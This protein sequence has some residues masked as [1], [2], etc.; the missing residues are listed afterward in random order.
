M[1]Q[2]RALDF[3]E[4]QTRLKT[5]CVIKWEKYTAYVQ[6][7]FIFCNEI[8]FIIITVLSLVCD[9]ASVQ[10]FSIFYMFYRHVTEMKTE[11]Q[12]MDP[13]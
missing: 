12:K 6:L 10:C 8:S 1:A 4:K 2:C 11:K 7:F 3:L 13:V 9:L 5:S